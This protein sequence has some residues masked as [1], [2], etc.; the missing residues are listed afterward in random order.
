MVADKKYKCNQCSK[1]YSYSG[2][3]AHI[4]SAHEGKIFE[5]D[6]CPYKSVARHNLKNHKLNKHDGVRFKCNL[7]D[8]YFYSKC[9][10]A[11]HTQRVHDVGKYSCSFCSK[12]FRLDSMLNEHLKSHGIVKNLWKFDS[13]QFSSLN[14]IE[15]FSKAEHILQIL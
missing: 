8:K 1:E 7:C 14:A 2:L 3:K 12:E 4:K 9:T 13:I 6:Q 5:C 15:M 11:G 10:L